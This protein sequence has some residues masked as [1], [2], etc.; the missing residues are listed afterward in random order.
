MHDDGARIKQLLQRGFDANTINPEGLHGLVLAIREPSPRATQALLDAPGIAVEVR[1]SQDESPLMLAALAGMNGVCERLIALNADVNKTGWTPLHYAASRS[2]TE[3]VR[4][5]L[6]HFA[7]VDAESP[8]RTT[9]L[10]M[11]A[12]Y[13]DTA[14][15]QALLDAGADPGLR[16]DKDM[17]AVDFALQSGNEDSA[18][19]IAQYLAKQGAR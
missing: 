3:T 18:R 16:N 19:L 7:Y 17:S 15:V 6:A 12:M 13:G 2:H 11:A 8:N 1:T 4:L 5:L 9:P 14:T 10:M